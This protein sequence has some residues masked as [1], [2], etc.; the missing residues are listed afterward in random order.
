MDHRIDGSVPEKPLIEYDQQRARGILDCAESYLAH[1]DELIYS[2]G[3][4]TFLS[5]Y[6]LFDEAHDMRGNIDCSTFVILVLSGIS[7]ENSPYGRGTVEGCG[8][9]REVWGD[10]E[11]FDYSNLP[12]QFVNIAERIGRPYL[13]GPKGLDLK[14]A[15]EMG[16]DLNT[17]AMEIQKS[18]VGRRSTQLAQHYLNTGACFT[19]PAC[20]MP[21]DIVFYNSKEYFSEGE[22][23]YPTNPEINHVGIASQDTK[24]MLN[25][26]G[27]YDKENDGKVKRPAVSLDPVFGDRTPVLFARI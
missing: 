5:G 7:Y 1:A 9:W 10:Q 19:D 13:A 3:S 20:L 8:R 22:R 21:G 24:L 16:I 26:S 11:L 6:E 15:E 2:F 27:T 12:K 4:R 25:S 14:K 18:G 23:K 17:L